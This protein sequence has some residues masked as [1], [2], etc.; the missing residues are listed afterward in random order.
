MREIGYREQ[1][2]FCQDIDM[3]GRMSAKY[4]LANLPEYLIEYRLGGSSHE[5]DDLSAAMKKMA[6][7]D[8]LRDLGVDFDDGDLER[9]YHLRNPKNHD[10]DAADVDWCEEWLMRLLTLNRERP[11][12]PEPE[13][14]RAASERW[15]KVARQAVGHGVSPG[16][17]LR[18]GTLLRHT[19]GVAIGFARGTLQRLSPRANAAR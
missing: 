9:H 2:V 19:P 8:L 7:A 13:F 3:W 6:A 16:R 15:W 11:S 12:Y 1:F 17:F 14:S 4:P 18:N 10:F 5:D